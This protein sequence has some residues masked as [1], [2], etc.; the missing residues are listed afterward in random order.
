MSKKTNKMTKHRTEVLHKIAE[1]ESSASS[2]ADYMCKEESNLHNIIKILEGQEMIVQVNYKQGRGHKEIF[3]GLTNKGIFYIVRSKLEAR[4]FLKILFNTYHKQ[5]GRKITVSIDDIFTEYEKT[6]MP[7]S[8][9]YIPLSLKNFLPYFFSYREFYENYRAISNEI[10]YR[11]QLTEVQLNRILD[12][13]KQNDIISNISLETMLS[14]MIITYDS[15]TKGFKL[16]HIG[17]LLLLEQALHSSGFT[18]DEFSKET[19]KFINNLKV[20]YRES[21]PQ[22]FRNWNELKEIQGEPAIINSMI[23]LNV[24]PLIRQQSVHIE[25][26][27]YRR[28]SDILELMAKSHTVYARNVVTACVDMLCETLSFPNDK[29]TVRRISQW[30]TTGKTTKLP[31]MKKEI[32]QKLDLIRKCIEMIEKQS[33]FLPFDESK[34]LLDKVGL[35]VNWKVRTSILEPNMA[36]QI[37][38]LFFTMFRQKFEEKSPLNLPDISAFLSSSTKTSNESIQSIEE[39]KQNKI[40]QYNRFLVENKRIS[41]Q[42][43]KWIDQVIEFESKNIEEIKVLKIE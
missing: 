26:D 31:R 16:S 23:S 8:E 25:N 17:I 20:N 42:Y 10:I 34:E 18:L 36:S 35:S 2:L 4:E 27:N 24:N 15:K 21:L 37:T 38:F 3:Y 11:D 19:S 40:K 1:R 30:T 7:F 41:E 32:V 13:R 22:I 5:T 14:T 33:N 12:L 28:I 39:L 6:N 9:N 43:N 29:S